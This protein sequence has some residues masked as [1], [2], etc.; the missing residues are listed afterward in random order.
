MNIVLDTNIIYSDFLFRS[1]EFDILLD[2]LKK[3]DSTFILPEVILLEI[4]QKYKES[5]EE[6]IEEYNKSS[7][8]LDLLQNNKEK[9]IGIIDINIENETKNYISFLKTKLKIRPKQIVPYKNEYLPELIK[10]AINKSKPFQNEDKGF[11]DTIIWLT[12]LD[13]CESTSRQIIFISNNPTDFGTKNVNNTLNNNLLKECEERKIKIIYYNT[14]KD[15][16]E[17]HSTK[18]DYITDQWIDDNLDNNIVSDIIW[19]K[20]HSA[21]SDSLQDWVERYKDIDRFEDVEILTI[22]PYLKD[23]ISIYEMVDGTLIINLRVV[24]EVEVIISFHVYRNDFGITGQ[25]M[26]ENIDFN[27]Y[28]SLTVKEKEIIDIELND[29]G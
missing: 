18:I 10:R 12:I 22:N 24:A 8:H 19:D 23:E 25:S 1:K 20:L 29:W 13:Y 14:I 2:Y 5:L 4:E 6:R 16:I 21:S 17:K 15:F 3:T 26:S 28:F 11:R 9:H 7:K 27:G